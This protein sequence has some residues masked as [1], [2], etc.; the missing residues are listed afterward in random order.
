MKLS[1][2]LLVLP[3]AIGALV[4]AGCGGDDSSD[5]GTATESAQTQTE[6]EQPAPNGNQGD[7]AGQANQGGAETLEI[8]AD[9]SGALAY[10]TTEYTVPAGNIT[11]DFTNDSQVPH[12]VVVNDSN[13]QEVAKTPVITGDSATTQ[14]T[15]TPGEYPFYCSVPGHEAAG[16]TGTIT[17]E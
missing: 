6:A 5:D 9:P 2:K 1:L 4:F 16:M 8:A 7:Q 15:A 11:I 13:G 10:E 3:L 17:V 14:F 12:D